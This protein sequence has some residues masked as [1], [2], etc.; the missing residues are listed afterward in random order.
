MTPVRAPEDWT[1]FTRRLVDSA[2]RRVRLHERRV[3][4]W[5]VQVDRAG[6]VLGVVPHPKAGRGERPYAVLAPREAKGRTNTTAPLLITDNAEYALGVVRDGQSP[7]RAAQRHAAYLALLEAHAAHPDVRAVLLAA[8]TVDRARLPGVN[9]TDLVT[10]QVGARNPHDDPDLQAAWVAF[11]GPPAGALDGM[12]ASTGRRG[13]LAEFTPTVTGIPGGM[14][15]V[16]LHSTFQDTNVH[17]GLRTLGITQDAAEAA[18]S[19][20]ARLA[21]DPVTSHQVTG[22]PVKLL[23]WLSGDGPSADPWAAL[24]RPGPEEV[25]AV[26]TAAT[27]LHDAPD[28]LVNVA[29]VTASSSRLRV[30]TYATLPLPEAAQHVSAFLRRTARRP[31]GELEAALS[32]PDRPAPPGLL[33]GLHLH[34][35]LGQPLPPAA[36]AT[37]MR[38]WRRTL[39]LTPAQAS[40]L[41]LTLPELPMPDP[42]PDSLSPARLAPHPA[43]ALPRPADPDL[44]QAYLLG[45]YA[46]DAHAAHRRANPGVGVTV[47]DRY[48]RLLAT[49]PVRAFA[50]MQQHMQA[51]LRNARSQAPGLAEHLSVTLAQA[52]TDITAP[53]PEHLTAAQQAALALGHQHRLAQ[54]NRDRQ[55]RFARLPSPPFPGASP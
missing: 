4:Q 45:A 29:V 21:R 53:L 19:T 41:A 34:A 40:L 5:T 54:L 31:L 37:L 52:V 14:A 10:Y 49:H 17:Y 30:L 6:Q 22:A 46:A 20:L 26:L 28:I 15:N 11:A 36:Q 44:R 38:L 7:A 33:T 13:P 39:D 23:H 18:A 8:R 51:V 1:S 35:L 50:L 42:D 2:E 12:D 16:V 48:L 9:A 27:P 3:P 55:A 43:S 47:T 32:A 24:T 25:H